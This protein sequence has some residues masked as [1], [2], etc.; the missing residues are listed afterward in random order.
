MFVV[1]K[2]VSVSAGLFWA[3]IIHIND[4]ISNSKSWTCGLSKK[5]G[6]DKE[7]NVSIQFSVILK[8]LQ[9]EKVLFEKML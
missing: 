1:S 9:L 7:D 6:C 2:K 8:K 3:K 5:F 4:V